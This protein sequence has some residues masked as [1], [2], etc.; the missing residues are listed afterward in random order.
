M[1]TN[2]HS[3][4]D[5]LRRMTFPFKAY[6]VVAPVIF[7]TWDVA[8]GGS[9]GGHH[10]VIRADFAAVILSGFL[11]CFLGFLIAALVQFIA[12]R[13]DVARVSLLFAGVAFVI[14]YFWLPM[15]AHS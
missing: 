14:C 10:G 2:P 3:K 4:H 13:R 12:H 1:Q 6:L 9:R 5:W 11:V 7:F 15:L 8:T